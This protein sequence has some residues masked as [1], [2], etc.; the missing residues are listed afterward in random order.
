MTGFIRRLLLL[1]PLSL[2][3]SFSNAQ[4][5]AQS[6][7]GDVVTP[8]TIGQPT[9]ALPK[10]I[11][12]GF[13][14]PNGWRITPAGK[15]IDTLED[16]TLNMVT[17]PDGK[18]VVA[19]HSGYLPHGIVVLDTKTQKEIQHIDMKT[20]WLGMTWSP[21]GHTL[22]VSGGNATGAKGIKGSPAP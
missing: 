5:P 18:V 17:S 11:P 8:R 1:V 2:Y 20:T 19:S 4:N 16:L 13:D 21:D 14:L 9:K 3:T 10:Y 7:P 12:G 15:A 22:Y 6:Q